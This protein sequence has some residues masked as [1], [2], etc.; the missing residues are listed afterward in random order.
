MPRS[1]IRVPPAAA[2]RH[3]QRDRILVALCP[4]F[5]VADLRLIKLPIGD[6][7]L[8]VVDEAGLVIRLDEVQR[9]GR[10]VDS[11][12]LRRERRGVMFKGAQGIGNLLKGA[13]N[14]LAIAGSGFPEPGD[15]SLALEPQRTAL[16]D[17]LRDIGAEI[18]E[19]P[20]LREEV[21]GRRRTAGWRSRG[22]ANT[23]S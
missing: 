14:R 17:R 2:Q 9:P 18:P 21:V 23:P 7:H 4:R 19:I 12:V 15:R 11:A 10:G 13:Q 16:E 6:Q 22:S 3:E 20:V 5:E 8:G 1:G